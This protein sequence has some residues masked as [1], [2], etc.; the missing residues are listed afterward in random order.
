MLWDEIIDKSKLEKVNPKQILREEIQKSFLALFSQEGYFEKMVFQGG[1]ALRLFYGNP[2]FSEDIDL[3]FRKN[4]KKVD[5][6]F[7]F[8]KIKKYTKIEKI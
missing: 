8:S 5:I 4:V 2:R 1:T 7:N 3:V 6:E